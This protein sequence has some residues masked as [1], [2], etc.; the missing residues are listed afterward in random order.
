MT[1][2]LSV[3]KQPPPSQPCTLPQCQQCSAPCIVEICPPATNK[4]TPTTTATPP[5]EAPP[6]TT[7]ATTPSTSTPPPTITT[8]SATTTQGA[9]STSCYHPIGNATA[10]RHSIGQCIIPATGGCNPAESVSLIATPDCTSPEALFSFESDGTLAHKCSGMRVLVS[11]DNN[12]IIMSRTA[13]GKKQ[14]RYDSTNH[15]FIRSVSHYEIP[16]PTLRGA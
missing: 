8:T 14:A 2:N 1:F 4:T 12:E 6:P 15:S 10:I 3:S 13:C 9:T 11:E 16:T 5:T 7:L